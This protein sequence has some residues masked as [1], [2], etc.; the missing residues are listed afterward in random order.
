LDFSNGLDVYPGF[1][2]LSFTEIPFLQRFYLVMYLCL[3]TGHCLQARAQGYS[4]VNYT[5]NDGLAGSTVYGMVRDKDDFLWFA[6]ETGLS[7]YDGSHFRN[8]YVSDGLPDNE[9][10]KLFVDSR[11]RVWIMPFKNSICYYQNGRI[12]NQSNDSLLR[13]LTIHGQVYSVTE[14]I[15][16][17]LLIGEMRAIDIISPEGKISTI[18]NYNGWPFM[19]VQAGLD[20][21][22]EVRLILSTDI[23]SPLVT[24]KNDALVR[25]GTMEGNGENNSTST[26]L[27]PDVMIYE[28]RDSLSFLYN[29]ESRALRMR[30][31]RGFLHISRVNDSSV[32]LNAYTSTY[33]YNIRSR[34]I[35]DSFL[36]GQMVSGVLE[37]PEGGLWFSTLG[38]GIHRLVSRDV[39]RYSF[40]EGST[41]FP[42]FSILQTG[43]TLYA[44]S[45]RFYLWSRRDGEK[46]FSSRKIDDRFSRG[47]IT[48]IE[49][50]HG[51]E[52]IAGTDAGVFGIGVPNGNSRLLWHR[53]SS[54]E[55][56]L[57]DDSTILEFSGSDVRTMRL[58][59]GE[60]LETIWVGRSTTGCLQGDRYYIG[61]L[62]GLYALPS[63]KASL[64]EGRK[65]NEGAQHTQGL[66]TDRIAAIAAAPGGNLWVG[67]YG[68]GVVL[69]HNGRPL[70]RYTVDDGL[71]SNI[72]KCL[73]TAGS[74][75]WVG[76]DKGLNKLSPADSGYTIT[77]ITAVQGLGS[78]T[79][80]TVYVNGGKVY[81]GT[82]DGLTVFPEDRLFRRSACRLRITGLR[83][84]GSSW[85]L[86]TA[87][88]K[89][90]YHDN[91]LQV[92][93]AGITYQ[94]GNAIRYRYR[95]LGIDE[96]W[97]TT[98]QTLLH[99]PGLPPGN[100]ELQILAVD[101]AGAINSAIQLPFS[102]DPPWWERIWVRLLL[103]L[104]ISGTV[105]VIFQRRIK[106]IQR[107]EVE[108]AWTAARMAELEQMALRSRMSPHFIFNCLNS[109]QLFV[110]EKDIRG[111]NDYITHFSRLIRQTLDI[112]ARAEISV[113]DE[114]Q[115][116]S[117]Y[118]ELEKRRFEEAFDYNIFV[119]AS[120]D[121]HI[122]TIP[123]MIL[124]PYVENAI[125]HGIAHREDRQGLITVSIR[126]EGKY[127]VCT[128]EDNGVGRERAAQF[129]RREPNPYPS[130]GMEMT[131]RR[132]EILNRTLKEPIDTVI[133]DI[134]VEEGPNSGTRVI[135][136][137]PQ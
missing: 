71:T 3:L 20:R 119:D 135:V 136:R 52:I 54:K 9:I 70:R 35:V 96:R 77:P 10:I 76:T 124:Q 84:A 132:I 118:L 108:K 89:L 110:M 117:T 94:S 32:T 53:G 39:V 116:L 51:R 87:H 107:K 12:H 74:T 27:G 134:P 40:R 33:L 86:D 64:Q 129:K 11:N 25:T 85:P 80:N 44:G 109:I 100:Y 56:Q 59:T 21:K 65:A 98:D 7:R 22:G 81:A 125:L 63:G 120:I 50:L 72:C 1:F 111:A 83:I 97:E 93:Y 103:L 104:A 67:T 8:F 29:G 55:L 91:D 137:F 37:D 14:D 126:L 90:P 31:P 112:S 133:L 130:R 115:Y 73:Y 24:V 66:L 88:F 105:W 46:E 41:V 13:R 45:D 17:N 4:Y 58:S 2:M 18:D 16:G 68:E 127:L 60:Y 48:S 78:E 42:V 30:A 43:N 34:K 128:I 38:D 23:G 102:I 95:L 15:H 106:T 123:T 131:A 5:V 28:D 79:I 36:P 113:Q 114:V 47:R 49:D 75:L 19:L 92:E 122:Q 26:Y 6:T 61:T 69:L 62:N 57:I 121:R 99:Y 101:P 82:R